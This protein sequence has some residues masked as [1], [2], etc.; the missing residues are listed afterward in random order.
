MRRG[1]KEFWLI[2]K[3]VINLNKSIIV[4]RYASFSW[5]N[6]WGNSFHRDLIKRYFAYRTKMRSINAVSNIES[7]KAPPGS[8]LA[9]L[10][11]DSFSCSRR[12]ESAG[13]TGA[14]RRR[15]FAEHRS[16][17][18]KRFA[19]ASASLSDS[20]DQREI[21]QAISC[22]PPPPSNRKKA[23]PGFSLAGL[24]LNQQ[25]GSREV[26]PVALAQF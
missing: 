17:P 20:S 24:F 2:A 3:T 7:P 12:I 22:L 19:L 9:G 18:P 14:G 23:P 11:C 16:A 10:F 6:S 1:K 4:S 15:G 8:S 5:G 25:L 13:G 26:H 21:A